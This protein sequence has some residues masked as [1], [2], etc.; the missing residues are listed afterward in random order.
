MY[1]FLFERTSGVQSV[2]V[3]RG[4]HSALDTRVN[5]ALYAIS[6]HHRAAIQWQR[7]VP[8]LAFSLFRTSTRNTTYS[9]RVETGPY[10]VPGLPHVVAH[11]RRPRVCC[12][13]AVS[14]PWMAVVWRVPLPSLLSPLPLHP[15]NTRAL[16]NRL[17]TRRLM[18]ESGP[19]SFGS[20]RFNLLRLGCLAPP[21]SL[22]T[23]ATI[24]QDPVSRLW[25][26]LDEPTV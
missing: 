12:S 20:R 6:H 11:S 10:F 24:T 23:T 21:S 18:H 15:P 26:I 2:C 3:R 5:H 14:S 4:V 16:P 17:V 13:T 25:N 7:P 8:P 19:Q 1:R 9:D 22:E